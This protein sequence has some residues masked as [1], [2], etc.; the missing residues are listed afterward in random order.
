MSQIMLRSAK[1]REP[2]MDQLTDPTTPRALT[3]SLDASVRDLA[4]GAV[5]DAGAVQ[6][7]AKSLLSAYERTRPLSPGQGRDAKSRRSGAA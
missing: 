5:R 7:E 4:S 3:D 6:A 2:L 1:F